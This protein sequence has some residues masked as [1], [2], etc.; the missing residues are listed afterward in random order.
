[1]KKF[2]IILTLS[3][4]SGCAEQQAK[5]PTAAQKAEVAQ[6]A[7]VDQLCAATIDEPDFAAAAEAELGRRQATCDWQKVQAILQVRQYRAQ[8]EQQKRD[9]AVNAYLQMRGQNMMQPQAQAYQMPTSKPVN[10]VTTYTGNQANTT[11]R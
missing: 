10:C 6:L 7:S 2:A 11:C 9:S 5:P 4:I 3:L 1:M 8:L